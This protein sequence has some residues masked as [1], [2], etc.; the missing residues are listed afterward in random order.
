MIDARI[1]QRE[2]GR[3][4]VAQGPWAQHVPE[5]ANP[6]HQ[7][8]LTRLAAMMDGRKA[9]IGAHA[10]SAVLPWATAALGPV[11]DDPGARAG[12]EQRAASIGAY[13][14]LS[15]YADPDDPEDPVGPEPTGPPDLRAVWHE[16]LTALGPAT[17]QDVRGI[18]DGRLL[19]LRATYPL[20]TAW[21]PAYVGDQLRQTR[22]AGRD[23]HYSSVT[24]LAEA[25]A[26]E[27]RGDHMR[28]AERR[29][30]GES[31]Q[32]LRD[33]Y[34]QRETALSVAADDRAAWEAATRQQRQAAVAADAELRRRYPD[35]PWE[36]LRST[37]PDPP[38]EP[39]EASQEQQVT[40]AGVLAMKPSLQELAARHRV[41][42]C[43]ITERAA[44]PI[45]LDPDADD[46]APSYPLAPRRAEAILQPPPLEIPPSP[47]ILS[48]AAQQERDWEAGD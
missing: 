36:P 41:I 9:R 32:A 16:A 45:P 33:A 21:A 46:R 34:R 37:E 24:K 23:A 15:G 42:A 7:A 43:K 26:A 1:R 38:P 28:A 25:T 19:Q 40:A 3:V 29:A 48:R 44:N 18:T 11:P 47:Y 8:Y 14:E 22:I 2:S 10:A 39:E 17:G 6:E 31:Y 20:E 5:V 30:L 13:R 35:Q 4:P 27:L 12:W